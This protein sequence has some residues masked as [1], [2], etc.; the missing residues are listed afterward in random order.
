[1]NIIDALGTLL[2][3]LFILA[4]GLLGVGSLGLLALLQL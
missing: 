2:V 1:M 4:A 3:L